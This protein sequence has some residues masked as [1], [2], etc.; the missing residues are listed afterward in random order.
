MIH[1]SLPCSSFPASCGCT[2]HCGGH[3]AWWYWTGSKEASMWLGV[4]LG[5]LVHGHLMGSLQDAH[6]QYAAIKLI[7]RN[8]W[9]AFISCFAKNSSQILLEFLITKVTNVGCFGRFFLLY[10]A[11]IVEMFLL[12]RMV[13][14]AISLLH[15]D[16]TTQPFMAFGGKLYGP[17]AFI[18]G[19]PNK[20]VVT[21]FRNFPSSGFLKFWKRHRIH[22]KSNI[23]RETIVLT[24]IMKRNQAIAVPNRCSTISCL[25][26]FIRKFSSLGINDLCRLHFH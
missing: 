9:R 23:P 7:I 20:D 19:F 4:S 21:S 1:T 14:D 3:S 8:L 15:P 11:S 6:P 22:P 13:R 24:Y 2:S 26:E 5:P 10:S 18:L 12:P 17:R 25:P 16:K